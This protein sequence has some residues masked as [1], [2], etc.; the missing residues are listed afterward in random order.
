MKADEAALRQRMENEKAVQKNKNELNA[1]E[2]ELKQKIKEKK[3]Q[4]Q[5]GVPVDQ[6]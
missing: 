4:E 3:E 1:K 2:E 5:N 6:P